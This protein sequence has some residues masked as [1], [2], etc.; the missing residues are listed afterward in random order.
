MDLIQVAS[1]K[2]LDLLEVQPGIT[3]EQMSHVLGLPG[4]RIA[5]AIRK[6]KVDGLVRVETIPNG[7]G[8]IRL[9]F[10]DE[11]DDDVRQRRM[12]HGTWSAGPVRGISSVFQL[13]GMA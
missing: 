4:A 12:P 10:L 7:K 6:L 9:W 13:G 1:D 11:V 2:V 5:N 3:K 8:H